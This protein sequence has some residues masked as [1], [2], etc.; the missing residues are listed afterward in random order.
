MDFLFSSFSIYGKLKII[1]GI[2]E[3][4]VLTKDGKQLLKYFYS[5]NLF[6]KLISQSIINKQQ[7][8]F[9]DQQITLLIIIFHLQNYLNSHFNITSSPT[10][11]PSS[12]SSPSSSIRISFSTNLNRIYFLNSLNSLLNVINL[13]KR[14]ICD[15]F[16][17][18]LLW[19][20]C[21]IN[22]EFIS[23]ICSH[24]LVPASNLRITQN[25][26]RIMVLFEWLFCFFCEIF[27][28]N[29]DVLDCLVEWK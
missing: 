21:Q 22:Q 3:R 2:N 27:F 14:T 29:L 1:K 5:F 8:I 4:N 12:S 20:E 9:G 17:S 19:K 25:L 24:I 23:N 18:L 13:L 28:S 10:S 6:L 7:E 26:T 16:L 11:I 15:T